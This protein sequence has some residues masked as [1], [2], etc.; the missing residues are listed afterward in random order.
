MMTGILQHMESAVWQ[1]VSERHYGGD[2][3]RVARAMDEGHRSSDLKA[4]AAYGAVR[5]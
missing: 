1:S 4:P 5:P 2:G 3:P